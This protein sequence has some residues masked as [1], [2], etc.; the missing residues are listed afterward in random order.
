MGIFYVGVWFDLD[1]ARA[2]GPDQ[3][4]I[5]R[6]WKRVVKATLDEHRKAGIDAPPLPIKA[7]I[8]GQP[9]VNRRW[10]HRLDVE[11]VFAGAA[12]R[13]V[14]D[15]ILRRLR[16]P[17]IPWTFA[18][19]L[20]GPE[21]DGP[22][23]ALTYDGWHWRGAVLRSGAASGLQFHR[24]V[25]LPM[26]Y[27]DDEDDEEW[28][29]A[30]LSDPKT[31]AEAF[32]HFPVH[33]GEMWTPAPATAPGLADGARLRAPQGA[34]ACAEVPAAALA[35]ALGRMSKLGRNTPGAASWK[36]GPEGVRV[37]WMGMA[38]LLPCEVAGKAIVVV[39][40][41]SMHALAGGHGWGETVQVVARASGLRVGRTAFEGELR[42]RP[43]PQLLPLNTTAK[44]VLRVHV[45]EDA[46][47]VD[48]A[49]LADAVA[50]VLERL[51]ES[52]SEAAKALSWLDVGIEELQAWLL[53]RLEK[54]DAPAEAA[55]ELVVVEANG[56]VR[57][58]GE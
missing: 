11:G 18:V 23:R 40:G 17:E 52:C 56:Q 2:S 31:V 29:G 36:F 51:D 3:G 8:C 14:A 5:K 54:P 37:A 7:G 9:W 42:D 20:M 10:R 6:V 41:P 49:G 21:Q 43:P 33:G 44:D 1:Q 48:E 46:G 27:V 30:D 26:V 50:E 34:V 16:H 53:S 13:A 57:L 47:R 55:P 38:E 35:T 25:K 15:K 28:M 22:V 19:E 58:F 24:Q 4:Y 32:A 45:R 12:T 39:D